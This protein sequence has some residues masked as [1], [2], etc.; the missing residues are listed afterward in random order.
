VPTSL[1][2]SFGGTTGVSVLLIVLASITFIAT[3]CA[4]ETRD[5]PL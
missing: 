3:L 5:A 2:Q 1:T 4:R